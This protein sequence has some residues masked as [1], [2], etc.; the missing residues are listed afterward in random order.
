MQILTKYK[1]G[2]L[3]NAQTA[4]ALL[5]PNEAVMLSREFFTNITATGVYGT[6]QTRDL[7][8]LKVV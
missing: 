7:A 1:G 4:D 2:S 5:A 3:G 8:V 6:C